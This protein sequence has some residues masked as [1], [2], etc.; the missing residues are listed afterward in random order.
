[1]TNKLNIKLLCKKFQLDYINKKS[2][3]K[4]SEINSPA[5]YRAGL[6]LSGHLIDSKIKRKNVVA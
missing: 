6:E 2:I 1:V 3:T 4:S 5:I